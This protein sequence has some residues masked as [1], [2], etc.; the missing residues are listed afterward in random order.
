MK[1]VIDA[2]RHELFDDIWCH[3]DFE[4]YDV[5]A[6]KSSNEP[7]LWLVY[8]DGTHLTMCGASAISQLF[9]NEANRIQM[10]REPK[11]PISALLYQGK[12]NDRY[13][14]F[15]WSGYKL[16][17]I[18]VNEAADIW[19]NLIGQ[20]LVKAQREHVEE[21]HNCEDPLPIKFA[22]EQAENAYLKETQ[23]AKEMDDG[24]LLDCVKRLQNWKRCE[25]NHY[26]LITMDFTDHSFCFTEMVNE[27]PHTNGGI[28]ADFRKQNNRWSIHT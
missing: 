9:D 22:S 13:K 17:R 2:L 18:S 11:A 28:I 8:P 16:E 3:N 12:H 26:I 6:L 21:C 14:C 10:F 4:K 25:L 20:T 7:F 5:P 23:L 24:S 1:Q 15:Y 27:T 19:G